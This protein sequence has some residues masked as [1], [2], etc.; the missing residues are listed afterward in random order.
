MITYY[1]DSAILSSLM[2]KLYCG[3]EPKAGERMSLHKCVFIISEPTL[4][5]PGCW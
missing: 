4:P 3:E 5:L 2:G 1:N